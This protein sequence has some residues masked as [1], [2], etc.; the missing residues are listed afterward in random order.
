MRTVEQINQAAETWARENLTRDYRYGSMSR[1]YP[2]AVR[3]GV[4]TD[5]ELELVRVTYGDRFYWTGD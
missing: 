3:A 5:D 1:W 2:G 4:I